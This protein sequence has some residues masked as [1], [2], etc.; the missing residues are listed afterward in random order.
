MEIVQEVWTFLQTPAGV[1]V[2]LA[3]IGL[4]ESLGG[5]PAVKANSVYQ[6]VIQVLQ[7]VATAVVKKPA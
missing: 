3:V 5:I 1:S 4:S 6:L 7:W 2:L